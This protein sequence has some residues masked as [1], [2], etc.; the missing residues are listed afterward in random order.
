M[1]R[2]S[3]AGA[4]LPAGGGG[5]SMRPRPDA[6]EKT[7]FGP[8]QRRPRPASM[9]P[10]PDAAEKDLEI[11]GDLEVAVASMRPRPDAAEKR[12]QAE[13]DSY[14]RLASMRPRPDAAEKMYNSDVSM[15]DGIGFNE[16]AARC[17]GKARCRSTPAPA[18]Y[19]LQ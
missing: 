19:W 4:H 15:R 9:R 12:I 13:R 16:A 10:R 14:V 8:F 6:A 17:R 3:V 11:D 18:W 1:P 2:K 7:R 5:A